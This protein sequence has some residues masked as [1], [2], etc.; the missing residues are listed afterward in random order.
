MKLKNVFF[1][2]VLGTAATA[3][4]SGVIA[5]E[6]DNVGGGQAGLNECYG[7]VFKKADAELNK[8]Y[9]EIE[10]RLKDD[11]DTQKNLVAAQRAWVS[12]RNAEC[13]LQ[14]SGGGSIVGTTYP[15]CQ[16]GLTQSRIEDFKN[17]LK[18]EEGDMSCPIPAAN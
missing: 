14:T 16:T 1:A 18:C 3:P 9:K 10:G 6:C 12:Y 11:P 5:D 8:L 15:I 7:K 2:A 13:D 4:L 17:Y